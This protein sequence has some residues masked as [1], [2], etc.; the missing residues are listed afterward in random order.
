MKKNGSLTRPVADK[1]ACNHLQSIHERERQRLESEKQAHSY[2]QNTRPQTLA[3]TR[4][5]MERTR[6]AT[7]Y[8]GVR[9]DVLQALAEVPGS[10]ARA[11]DH[12][13]G[14]GIQDTDPDILSARQD[15]Q[16]IASLMTAVDCILN[17]CEET[18]QHTGRTL[19]CWLRS[20]KPHTCYPK[21]FT[22]VALELSKKKYQR[23][24]KSFI[25][26]SFCA[27]RMPWEVRW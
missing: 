5:W 10:P 17:R 2:D 23:L 26:F 4:P 25:A 24:W 1:D 13:L 20:T 9:R 27:Y 7:T 18:V 11:A 6:W 15:E 12:F 16:K 8:D 21:P 14:Q 3:A 19:L 22:L